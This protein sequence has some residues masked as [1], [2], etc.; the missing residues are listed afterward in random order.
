MR[1]LF[2]LMAVQHDTAS[3]S[4]ARE[5]GVSRRVQRRLLAEGLLRSPYPGVLVASGARL[6]FE[7]RAMAATLSPGVVA[8]SHGAAARLHRLDGFDRHETVDVLGHR[9]AH[10]PARR[11]V[12]IHLTRADVAGHVTDVE[13]I[14]V[15]TIAATL[16]LLAPSAGIGRTAQALDSAL[17]R[18]VE[19]G[20]LRRVAMTWRQQGRAGPPALLMLL[21]ERVERRL[22][23]SWFQRLA[24]GVLAAVG[25]RLVDQYAVRDDRGVLLAALDLA[26]PARKVGVESQS[27][28]WHATP[29][30][31]HR[32]ARRRGLLRQL[33]WEVVD[34]W[35]SDLRQ[36]E[37]VIGELTY[38]LRSRRPNWQDVRARRQ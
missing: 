8:I 11:D 2:Q 29:S 19:A 10:L 1:A 20:E 34:V 9:G 12:T 26:D 27:W 37:R 31:Q 16:A 25:I 33:G 6:T 3:T 23:R 38:L 36:P 30:S 15:L 35:W 17:R 18:G 13:G 24:A 5:L 7:R 4:Q 21:G 22:P 14:P 28:E 32:D